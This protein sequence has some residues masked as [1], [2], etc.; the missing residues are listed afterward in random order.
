MAAV[1]PSPVTA[2]PA[3]TAVPPEPPR[4]AVDAMKS[5]L[6]KK[7]RVT[8]K[9][10]R[11]FT[12]VFSVRREQLCVCLC[13]RCGSMCVDVDIRLALNSVLTKDAI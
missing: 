7:L 9:D 11:V 6:G 13:V 10:G 3:E 1:D 5:R 12:G 8:I 4:P 2:T